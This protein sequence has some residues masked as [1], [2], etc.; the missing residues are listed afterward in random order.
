MKAR[1]VFYSDRLTV[2]LMDVSMGLAVFLR[3]SQAT[4]AATLPFVAQSIVP[5][6]RIDGVD[7]A[8]K[9]TLSGPVLVQMFVGNIT[10]WDDPAIKA[11]NPALTFPHKFINVVVRGGE[12]AARS[13]LCSRATSLTRPRSRCRRPHADHHRVLQQDQPV[14][15]C[16]PR[17][18]DG[19]LTLLNEFG[20]FASQ[21]TTII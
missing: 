21:S 18:R 10:Y 3:C 9:L 7:P 19:L 6:W 20:A 8:A 13:S 12:S 5:C 17:C 15:V 11:L 2:L 1:V 16:K 14:V 4:D